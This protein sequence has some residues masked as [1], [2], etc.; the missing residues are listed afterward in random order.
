MQAHR[1]DY[2]VEATLI[3][4][5]EEQVQSYLNPLDNLK[6]RRYGSNQSHWEVDTCVNPPSKN[7]CQIL[8]PAC[9]SWTARSIGAFTD[10]PAMQAVF[11][12]ALN[13]RAADRARAY[14]R[15]GKKPSRA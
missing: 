2:A 8:K 15:T 4:L 11:A 13:I 10:D 9:R 1:Y 7:A 6:F 12:E 14:R 5:T 3:E